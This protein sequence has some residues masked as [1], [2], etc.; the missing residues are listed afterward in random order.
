MHNSHSEGKAENYETGNRKPLDFNHY[1]KEIAVHQG[2]QFAT[3]EIYKLDRL[4]N[5]FVISCTE[6]KLFI[7]TLW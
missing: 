7:S 2:Q 6:P 3:V 4:V 1:S 5:L